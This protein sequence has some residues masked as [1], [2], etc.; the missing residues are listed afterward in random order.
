MKSAARKDK[1]VENRR[2]EKCEKAAVVLNVHWGHP[3]I[4]LRHIAGLYWILH[5]NYAI[6]LQVPPDAC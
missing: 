1:K 5:I 2:Q 6:G 4:S 3:D